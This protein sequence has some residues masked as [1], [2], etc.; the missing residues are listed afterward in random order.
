MPQ[1][2][3]SGDDSDRSSSALNEKQTSVSLMPSISRKETSG[4][5]TVMAWS[6]GRLLRHEYAYAINDG[7]IRYNLDGSY[8][9]ED[10]I[11]EESDVSN[12]RFR[13]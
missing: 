6:R 1:V 7:R 8:K 13:E 11:D 4:F 5:F 10:I 2:L 9:V 3:F 12:L